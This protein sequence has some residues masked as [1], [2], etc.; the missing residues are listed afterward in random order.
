[1]SYENKMSKCQI[2]CLDD[3]YARSLKYSVVHD[4]CSGSLVCWD[5]SLEVLYCVPGTTPSPVL[6][7]VRSTLE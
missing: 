4:V 5:V 2:N 6:C 3:N 7:I 1:M